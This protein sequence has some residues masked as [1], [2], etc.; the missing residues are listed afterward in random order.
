MIEK[1]IFKIVTNIASK[2]TKIMPEPVSFWLCTASVNYLFQISGNYDVQVFFLIQIG[3]SNLLICNLCIKA[4]EQYLTHSSPGFQLT[5][6]NGTEL[7]LGNQGR[8]VCY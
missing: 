3:H 8:L 5:E 7:L 4:L 6:P 2:H 1:Q